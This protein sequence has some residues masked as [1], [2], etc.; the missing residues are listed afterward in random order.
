[1][2]EETF[3]ADFTNAVDVTATPA[4]R[5]RAVELAVERGLI[6]QAMRTEHPNMFE[7]VSASA[8][9]DYRIFYAPQTGSVVCACEAGM[10]QTPCGHAGAVLLLITRLAPERERTAEGG[11]RQ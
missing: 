4:W 5:K 10:H 8:P 3:D 6:G 2:G 7:C 11:P 1:M 9:R